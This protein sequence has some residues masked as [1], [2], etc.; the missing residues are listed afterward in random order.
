MDAELRSF[1]NTS[2]PS[3]WALELL[4]L[5]RKELDRSFAAD[6]IVDLLRASEAVV[7]RSLVS[8]EA[9]GLV[10]GDEDRFRYAPASPD[11]ERLVEATLSTYRSRPDAVRRLIVSAGA[12]GAQLFADAFRLRRDDR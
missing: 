3:V 12:S 10:L 4:A 7:G 5:L 2:F 9:A 1:I 8:L 11:L 6:Q